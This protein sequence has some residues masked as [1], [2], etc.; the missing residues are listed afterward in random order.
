LSMQTN[1]LEMLS[2]RIKEAEERL[3]RVEE[4]NEEASLGRPTPPISPLKPLP[5]L[6]EPNHEQFGQTDVME[7]DWR[8]G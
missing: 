5:S 8:R 7:Q 3:R 2:Q 6:P 4:E 1:E